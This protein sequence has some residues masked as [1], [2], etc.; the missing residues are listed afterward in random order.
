MIEIIQEVLADVVDHGLTHEEIER[1]KGAVRG[2]LVLSQEDT[3]SRM[4]R[5]GKSEIVYGEIMSFDEILKSIARVTAEEVRAVASEFLIK[6][7]TLAVV[8]PH[9][10]LRKFEK[11]LRN[12]GS[13]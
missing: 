1:A 3:G 4:S 5:I 2:S 12:G 11:V 7:P 8:G 9:K 6:S 13:K 10:D